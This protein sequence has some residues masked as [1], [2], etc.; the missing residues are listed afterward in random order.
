MLVFAHI[1]ITRW[2]FIGVDGHRPIG[3]RPR[4]A[5][6][7]QQVGS[8]LR[9][10]DTGRHAWPDFIDARYPRTDLSADPWMRPLHQRLFRD[11][12]LLWVFKLLHV[13]HTQSSTI[14]KGK[15]LGKDMF[16]ETNNQ[17]QRYSDVLD[18]LMQN[19]RDQVT[20]D[21]AIYTHRTGKNCTCFWCN[22]YSF[23][24]RRTTGPQRYNL[25]SE[26]RSRHQETMPSRDAHRH[27]I[28]DH[29][30][31]QQHWRR[32]PTRVVAIW[33]CRQGQIS[34]RPHDC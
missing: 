9:L 13:P 16:T 18:A 28:R 12:E 24:F 30:L 6:S 7:C 8:S 5:W 4:S 10:H 3:S 22:S 26:R 2:R 1:P 21:V 23:F 27:T 29:R 19:F 25:C 15:R 14:I 32:R 20:R 34:D 17:I 31:G 33:P 11:Q